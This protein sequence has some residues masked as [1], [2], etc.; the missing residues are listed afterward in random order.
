MEHG[1]RDREEKTAEPQRG[2][3]GLGETRVQVPP[4]HPL[5]ESPAV[6]PVPP[7]AESPAVPPIARK[8][9]PVGVPAARLEAGE[10]RS[11]LKH[12]TCRP[13][14]GQVTNKDQTEKTA[15]SQRCRP[16]R[17]RP[18]MSGRIR[19]HPETKRLPAPKGT[20]SL[21]TVAAGVAGGGGGGQAR[22][23]WSHGPRKGALA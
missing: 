14:C 11:F 6:P 3:P 2:G 20:A 5:A 10:C 18:G 4:V 1:T 17:G 21:R 23:D 19:K 22:A 8:R 13:A 12:Q 7:L 16:Q 15:S 9:P